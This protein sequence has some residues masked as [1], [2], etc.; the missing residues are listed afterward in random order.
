M[1]RRERRRVAVVG[2]QDVGHLG[3]PDAAGRD[4]AEQQLAFQ[5]GDPRAAIDEAAGDRVAAAAVC[6]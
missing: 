1:H 6:G 5:R 3:V 2:A 4:V